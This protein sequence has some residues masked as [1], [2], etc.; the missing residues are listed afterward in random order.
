MRTSQ[1]LLL[2]AACSVLAVS[3][4]DVRTNEPALSS[5]AGLD[6]R[7]IR[8]PYTGMGQSFWKDARTVVVM[9]RGKKDAAEG[10]V[11]EW[12][13]GAKT[14]RKINS[15]PAHAN[16]PFCYSDGHLDLRGHQ[17]PAFMGMTA[18]YPRGNAFT[19]KVSEQSDFDELDRRRSGYA[20]VGLLPGH[21]Y[22][23]GPKAST[24]D[25]ADRRSPGWIPPK[26][27]PAYLV[28]V[29][30]KDDIR[31]EL[32][33]CDLPNQFSISY[34]AARGKYLLRPYLKSDMELLPGCHPYYEKGVIQVF[35]L[36]PDGSL[37]R[38]SIALPRLRTEGN[39]G[40]FT[41]VWTRKGWIAGDDE[42]ILF[43]SKDS[44]VQIYAKPSKGEY[45]IT[46]V[47]PDGCRVGIQGRG[48]ERTGYERVRWFTTQFRVLDVCAEGAA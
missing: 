24:K 45:K 16:I 41:L 12:E 8:S 4:C 26:P 10:D 7:E 35:W 3:G 47:S 25:Y 29:D 18:L 43:R 13:V 14:G 38:E 44:W 34:S 46:S 20:F 40:G 33:A 23:A 22:L 21:G 39:F 48:Y 6:F 19:C 2:G 42:R 1:D 15:Q 36:E 5:P 9:H 32:T 27:R 37:Q 11:I 17:F 31:L 30:R 28:H